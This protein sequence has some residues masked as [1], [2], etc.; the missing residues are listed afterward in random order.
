MCIALGYGPVIVTRDWVIDS[1][2][3]H[4]ILG[5][6]SFDCIDEKHRLTLDS[7]CTDTEPYRLRD[8]ER[9]KLLHMS[10]EESLNRARTAKVFEDLTFYITPKCQPS[11]EAL[12]RIIKAN[13]GVANFKFPSHRDLLDQ[14]QRFVIS[15]IGDR[16][17][18]EKLSTTTLP[19]VPIYSV[20]AILMS[21]L[22]Q[23]LDFT[24]DSI[25]RCDAK[26]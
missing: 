12:Q 21:V 23:K 10:L 24:P 17:L 4:K 15:S 26:M 20:E 8:H 9:E 11:R 16:P 14:P 25:H 13:G 5:K 18:W 1:I 2:S 6:V 19:K 3:Q 7:F 22:R